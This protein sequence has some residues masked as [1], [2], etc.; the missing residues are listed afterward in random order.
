MQTATMMKQLQNRTFYSQRIPDTWEQ[1]ITTARTFGF[2][3]LGSRIALPA[4]EWRQFVLNDCPFDLTVACRFLKIVQG[5]QIPGA[6]V[7]GP[8]S[9]YDVIRLEEP[10]FRFG[11]DH[12]LV[13]TA[14]TPEEL[15]ALKKQFKAS[16]AATSRSSFND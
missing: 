15:S 2:T 12:A 1:G 8:Y 7:C 13:T 3:L 10:L 4:D 16:H 11:V 14:C 5:Q 6:E 9:F